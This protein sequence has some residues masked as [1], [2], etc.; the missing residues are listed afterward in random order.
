[1]FPAILERMEIFSSVFSLGKIGF[2]PICPEL[3]S[4]RGWDL[5]FFFDAERK[6]RYQ[7]WMKAHNLNNWWNIIDE[8]FEN[9]ICMVSRHLRGKDLVLSWMFTCWKEIFSHFHR[10]EVLLALI[11]N[12]FNFSLRGNWWSLRFHFSSMKTKI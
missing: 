1:M 9:H 6:L 8:N 5:L 12:N 4:M 3:F 11:H 10:H 7:K 2:P